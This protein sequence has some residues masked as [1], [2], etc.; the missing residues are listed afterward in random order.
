M[1]IHEIKDA[2][3]NLHTCLG[4]LSRYDPLAKRALSD[5]MPLINSAKD[6]TIVIPVSRVPR[7]YDFHEGELR[8]YSYLVEAYSRFACL[9]M[10][11]DVH[12]K[13]NM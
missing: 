11:Y 10:G 13:S 1:T 2:A 7:G 3:M 6:G 12:S 4:H 9:V 8:K 5:L